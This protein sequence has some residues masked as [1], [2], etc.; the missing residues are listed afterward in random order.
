MR[1]F[2]PAALSTFALTTLLIGCE[3]QI[4]VSDELDSEDELLAYSALQT[5][6]DGFALGFELHGRV[7]VVSEPDATAL[8]LRVSSGLDV[9]GTYPAHVHNGSCAEGGGGHYLLDPT[10]APSEENEIWLPISSENGEGRAFARVE[11]GLRP[12]ARS[13][14]VHDPVTRA[15]IACADMKLR[16]AAGEFAAL[17]A[18]VD[19]GL[20][21]A[22]FGALVASN[23]RSQT[24]VVIQSG[25]EPGLVYPSH[26]HDGTCADGGGGHY[27]LDPAVAPAEDNEI[28]LSIEANEA[29]GAFASTRAAGPIRLDAQSIVIHH[30][31]TRAKIACADLD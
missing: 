14:V 2:T 29:G 20:E 9:E 23:G 3:G 22:G 7:V 11:Q 24:F 13:V 10:Q 5:T 28:W 25:L 4:H 16:A 12:D 8:A 15:K 26:V 19:L 21:I 18:G 31:E 30:P 17:P 1:R 27:L 6:D